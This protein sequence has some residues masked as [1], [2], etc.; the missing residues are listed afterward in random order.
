MGPKTIGSW[1][2][3]AREKG[4]V[5]EFCTKII[6]KYLA[7]V[8]QAYK[9]VG[10]PALSKERTRWAFVKTYN[11]QTWHFVL[12]LTRPLFSFKQTFCS[13]VV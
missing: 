5:R 7:Y 9:F 10:V 11:G 1:K 12:N 8:S 6:N 3:L 2:R 4:L 13:G